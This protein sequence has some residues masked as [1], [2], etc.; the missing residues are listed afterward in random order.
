[1]S[2]FTDIPA[3]FLSQSERSWGKLSLGGDKEMLAYTL[4]GKVSVIT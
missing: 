3:D 2:T 1:M 4:P